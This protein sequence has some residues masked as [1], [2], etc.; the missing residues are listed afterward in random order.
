MRRPGVLLARPRPG[1][2]LVAVTVV[3]AV[4]L[5]LLP[6]AGA[7]L[8]EA[9]PPGGEAVA[10]GVVRQTHSYGPHGDENTYDV[11]LPAGEPVRPRPTVLF[12]HGGSWEIGDKVE[13]VAEAIEVAQRG[14]T[15]VSLNYRRTPT[16]PWP[17]PLDDVRAALRHLQQGAPALGVDVQRTGALGDS[18]GAQLAALL[19]RPVPGT[20]PVRAVVAWSGI[21]D[22]PGLTQQRASGGCAAPGCPLQGPGPQGRRRPHALHARAVPDGLPRRLPRRRA[23]HRAGHVRRQQRDRADRP[24][25]GL[26]HGRRAVAGP[27]RQPGAGARRRR[28]R[29]RLPGLGVAGLACASWPPRS[30]PRPPP[31][32]PGR[33]S[34]SGWRVADADRPPRPAGGA[35]RAGA[36]ARAR[37]QR[38]PAG[39]RRRRRRGAPPARPRCAPRS[40]T[41]CSTC[42]GRRPGAGTTTWRAL[43]RGG[44]GEGVS[45]PV[46]VTAR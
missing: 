45:A 9:G 34:A 3:V 44:G 21:N 7:A 30:P 24:A 29:P 35:V 13:Y 6:R 4:L 31:R 43:W 33:P 16:A 25:P 8:Q 39:P 14:W 26:G 12:V 5:T 46:T 22:M 23:H 36:A 11:Y 10:N 20:T 15:A 42:P 17:A 28:P 19:G 32:S 27:R 1:A 18:V 38:R 41:P 37:Q 2:L 40:A